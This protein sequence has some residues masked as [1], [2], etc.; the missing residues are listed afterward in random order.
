MENPQK[1]K[2]EYTYDPTTPP[3]GIC[4]A[5]LISYSTDSCSATFIASV[6][7]KARKWKQSICPSTGELLMKIQYACMT[8]CYSAVTKNEIMNFAG[9]WTELQ[10]IIPSEEVTRI[11]YIRILKYE[12]TT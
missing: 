2:N 1:A 10:K 6:F 3:L 12:Y 7:R 5:G 4:P 9:K 11:Q 8:E